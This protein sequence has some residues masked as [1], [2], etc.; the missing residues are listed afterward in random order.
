MGSLLWCRSHYSK[1][2]L[3]AS[4]HELVKRKK[5]GLEV[6]NLDNFERINSG[7]QVRPNFHCLEDAIPRHAPM[8]EHPAAAKL[9]RARAHAKRVSAALAAALARGI[10]ETLWREF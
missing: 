10:F 2:N 5:S 8:D 9:P 6:V 3:S 7:K 1:S 4:C